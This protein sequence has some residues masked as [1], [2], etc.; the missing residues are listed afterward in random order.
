MVSR[1]SYLTVVL[2]CLSAAGCGS[3]SGFPKTYPVSGVVT[4]NG[5]PVEGAMVTFQL[6][7]GKE[8]AI[9]T[10]DSTGEYK[11]TMFQPGDG[12]I[13]GQYRVGV[14][15]LP[16][17]PPAVNTPPAGTLAS[18]ELG[19]NYAPP[20]QS[21]TAAKPKVRTEIPEK[22]ANDQTSALRA[23]VTTAGPNRFDFDLK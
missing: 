4:Y 14:S 18:G 22:Y 17:A 12:A 5:K 1:T 7:E 21:E 2:C 23:T 8:N 9:G 20:A 6:N 15:K 10:T 11:L 3:G 16:P 19:A 13:P